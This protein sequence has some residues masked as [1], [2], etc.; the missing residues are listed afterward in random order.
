MS[1]SD[2]K[3]FPDDEVPRDESERDEP[4]TQKDA[5]A[6]EPETAPEAQSAAEFPD[7]EPPSFPNLDGELAS[8]EDFELP[9]P[10]FDDSTA[11]FQPIHEISRSQRRRRRQHRLLVMPEEGD[12]SAR[13]ESMARRAAPT[14]DFFVFSLLCGAV[15]GVGYLLD[16]SA[17]LLAALLVAPVLAPWVG[18][19]LAAA[20]G[21][22][23]F[24]GQTLGGFFTAIVMI[25]ATG[26]LA[27]LASRIWLPM[28]FS[29][30]FLHARLWWP[31]LA[32][33]VI[34]TVILTLAFIQSEEKPV[35]PSIMLAYGFFLPTSAAGFGLGNS[36]QGL[37]PQALLVLLVYLAI[38]L[39]ISV[40]VFYFMRFRPFATAGYALGAGV[41]IVSVVIVAGIAG[42][43]SIISAQGTREPPT[44]IVNE[45]RTPTP[46]LT[47]QILQPSATPAISI[48][49]P[50]II[51]MTA[52]PFLSPTPSPLPTPI[53]GRI[54]SPGDGAIIRGN[55]SGAPITTIQNG[56]L[57]EIQPDAPV[58][59]DGNYWIHVVVKT[60][61]RDIDGWVLQNLIA[62]ATPSLAS[63]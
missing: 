26:F 12:L 42:I 54:S 24:M 32:L 5:N 40:M 23:R 27:G 10:S 45:V 3:P 13:L 57:V 33:V 36:V 53:Y 22:I 62:T 30:A 2:E 44:A 9:D 47:A 37:W 15:L 50:S 63:P 4:I 11:E 34:G 28:T 41:F 14:F 8:L 20:T 16:S 35:L 7:E 31:D 49:T 17:I 29:Q 39:V 55:P 48:A 58:L 43:G 52:T 21:E 59:K 18:V 38:S 56:Y 61:S 19:G 51:L 25:F 6:I 1:F 60:A 46:A